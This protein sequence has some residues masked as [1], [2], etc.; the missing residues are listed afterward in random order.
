MPIYSVREYRPFLRPVGYRPASLGQYD[1]FTEKWYRQDLIKLY[2]QSVED[3][4]RNFDLIP[5]DRATRDQATPLFERKSA[6]CNSLIPTL[7]STSDVEA[8]KTTITACLNELDKIG[9]EALDQSHAKQASRDAWKLPVMLTGIGLF[10]TGMILQ[11]TTKKAETV[12][13]IME[14]LGFV[15][16]AAVAPYRPYYRYYW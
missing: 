13:L 8:T 15:T 12:G 4:K 7:L 6:E 10:A 3:H 9:T 2:A 1:R 16:V 5:M 14:G 11:L